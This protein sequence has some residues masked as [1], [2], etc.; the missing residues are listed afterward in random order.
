MGGSR[1]PRTLFLLNSL[2]VGG[3]EKQVVTLF[4]GLTAAGHAPI[5]QCIKL[6]D[7]LLGQL[8]P[9]ARASVQPSLG[10]RSGIEWHAVRALARRLDALAIDVVLCT[11]MYALLYGTLARALARRRGDIQLVEVFHTTEVASRKEQWSMALYRR[12]VRSADLLVYV[13]HGQATHWLDRGLHARQNAVIYN[14][15]DLRRFVDRPSADGKS[16]LRERFGLRRDDP[17]V[18]LCAVMR[19]EKAHAD[20]LEALALLRGR[21]MRVQALLIGDGPLRPQ[22][23]ARIDALGLRDDVRITGMLDDVRPAISACDAMALPSRETFSIAA[24]EA[25]AMGRPMIMTRIGGALE[26]VADGLDGRLYPAGDTDALA[27]AIASLMDRGRCREMGRLAAE[28]V[29]QAFGVERMVRSYADALQALAQRRP[30]RSD[31]MA[32]PVTTPG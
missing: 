23:Q 16:A 4:N 5:L 7:A 9:A 8:S 32:G 3:A 14:G 18:G 26:Q 22:L 10:V 1:T 11:N 21:G 20:L 12:V 15:I 19:P 6:D 29:H 30:V 27:Q 25:M 24:L 17:V 2:C 13:C 28:R 31:P